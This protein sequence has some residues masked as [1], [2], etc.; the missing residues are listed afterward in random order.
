MKVHAYLVLLLLA[1]LAQF[2]TAKPNNDGNAGVVDT[3]KDAVVEQMLVEEVAVKAAARRGMELSSEQLDLLR[4]DVS[5]KLQLQQQLKND[6][7]FDADD[8]VM[9][10][11]RRELVFSSLYDRFSQLL[12]Q[13]GDTGNGDNNDQGS[14]EFFQAIGD[15]LDQIMQGLEVDVDEEPPYEIPTSMDHSASSVGKAIRRGRRRR[16]RPRRNLAGKKGHGAG[17]RNVA[18]GGTKKRAT[19]ATLAVEAE[20]A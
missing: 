20:R 6:P 12:G 8:D 16:G 4:K 9:A 15:W 7:T 13:D 10:Q 11:Q 19:A 14:D 1:S 3:A 5:D 18:R 17:R 2:A